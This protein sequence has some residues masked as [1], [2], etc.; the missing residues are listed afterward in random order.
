MYKEASKKDK[1]RGT[2]FDIH[3]DLQVSEVTSCHKYVSLSLW[4]NDGFLD[5]LSDPTNTL[6]VEQCGL[7]NSSEINFDTDEKNLPSLTE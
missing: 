5:I 2:N 7:I 3:L 6:D 1:L 4:E